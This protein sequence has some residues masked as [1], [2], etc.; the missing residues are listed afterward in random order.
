MRGDHD[1]YRGGDRG[2]RGDRRYDDRDRDRGGHDGGS[3]GGDRRFDRNNGGDMGHQDRSGYGRDDRGH[4]GGGSGRGGY[5]RDDRDRGGYAGRGG[6]RNGGGGGRYDRRGPPGR[7]GGGVNSHGDRGRGGGGGRGPQRTRTTIN[8]SATEASANII[9]ANVTNNFRFHHYGIDG[10]TAKGGSI[11]SRRRKAELFH[12]GIFDPEHGLLARNKMSPKEIEDFRRVTFFEGSFCYTSRKIPFV[13]QTPFSLVGK[14]VPE[15]GAPSSD[16]GDIM[17]IMSYQCF[18]V[19]EQLMHEN[20]VKSSADGIVVDLRCA[21]STQAFKTK[22]ALLAHCKQT[23]HSPMTDLDGDS[24]CS[25]TEQFIGYCNVALQRAMGERMARW[26]REYIDPKN[27][28]E[29]TDRN[30][31]SMGVR[32]FRAFV[33]IFA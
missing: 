13:T 2:G 19:P 11:D 16:N 14:K 7:G 17:T 28:T 10:S 30:G 15:S 9:C 33:S 6:E 24:K 25:T 4:G 32:I 12:F 3:G 23:G 8:M 21:D 18:H 22:D 20:H 31:R 5:E 1:G 29:P 27:W 26:G